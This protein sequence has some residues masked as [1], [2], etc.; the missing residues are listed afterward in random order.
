MKEYLKDLL[1]RIKKYSKEL[2]AK[3]ILYNKKWLFLSDNNDEIVYIFRPDKELIVTVN[4]VGGKGKWEILFENT[5]CIEYKEEIRVYNTA[6]VDN[7]FL[8]LQLDS[9]LEFDIL[10]DKSMQN[11][12]NIKTLE[13]II[14]YL[15]EYLNRDI[16][17]IKP[18]QQK[19]EV[20]ETDIPEDIPL[21]TNKIFIA[22]GIIVAIIMLTIMLATILI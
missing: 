10:V 11:I 1:P 19:I 5:I 14:M 12:N 16:V 2:D 15:E 17:E 21:V 20:L 3:T 4:G 13:Y 9:N 18:I 8:A 6:F 7:S 22:A